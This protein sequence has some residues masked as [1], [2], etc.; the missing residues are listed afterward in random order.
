MGSRG[1]GG[2]VFLVLFYSLSY[3]IF[4]RQQINLSQVKSVLAMTV[5]GE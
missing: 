4:N 2:K 3:S 5:I 1:T